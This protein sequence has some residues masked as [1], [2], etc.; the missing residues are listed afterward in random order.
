MAS[1]ANPGATNRTA[2]GKGNY[3]RK[4]NRPAGELP[5][6]FKVCELESL[7]AFLRRLVSLSQPS[8]ESSEPGSEQQ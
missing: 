3:A 5:A 4:G 7:T 8:A 2:R 6:S 1:N